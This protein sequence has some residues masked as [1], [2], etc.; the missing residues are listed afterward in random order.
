[1][2]FGRSVYKWSLGPF[3]FLATTPASRTALFAHISNVFDHIS[4]VFMVGVDKSQ[5]FSPLKSWSSSPLHVEIEIMYCI[6]ISLIFVYYC[7]S[8]TF[9]LQFCV[10]VCYLFFYQLAC[11]L[12]SCI[13][14]LRMLSAVANLLPTVCRV[15]RRLDLVEA[16]QNLFPKIFLTI[17]YWVAWKIQTGCI[18]M[19]WLKGCCSLYS[20]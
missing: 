13:M 11:F 8:V 14:C 19:Y 10:S 1:M 7:L 17:T 9:L 12:A 18:K 20:S 6:L 2:P 4:S 5:K 16:F 15:I 3:P